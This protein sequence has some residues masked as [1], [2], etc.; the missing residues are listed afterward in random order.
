MFPKFYADVVIS[1]APNSPEARILAR[2][3]EKILDRINMPI[4]PSVKSCTH[5]KV[6]GVRCGSPAL[7][8]EQFCYF[9]QRMIRGVHIPPFSR[10]HPIALIEDEEAIQASLMEVINALIRNTIDMRRAD[11]I[12]KALFIAS[13]NSRRARFENLANTVTQVPEYP[14]P[15]RPPSPPP[16]V[17][18]MKVQNTPSGYIEVTPPAPTPASTEF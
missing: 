13:K 17:Q 18:V 3:Y 14:A 16:A 7:R 6:T 8:G 11:L 10:L 9:H 12:L 4:H 1:S 2:N 5:I 15:P